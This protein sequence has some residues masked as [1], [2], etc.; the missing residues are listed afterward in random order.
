MISFTKKQKGTIESIARRNGIDLF[1]LFGSRAIGREHARSDFDIAYRS[2]MPLPLDG[3]ARL[4]LDL[5]SLFKSDDIDLVNITTAPPLLRY[6][7]FKDGIPIYEGTP[8]IFASYAVFAFKS[9]VEAQPLFRDK[10]RYLKQQA[11]SYGV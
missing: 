11:E 9:Y 10:L 1:V 2:H 6:A 4:I 8:Y 3:E 5:S 7:V